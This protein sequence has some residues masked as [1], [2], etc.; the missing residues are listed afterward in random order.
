MSLLLRGR[1][2]AAHGI[3]LA[4]AA[5]PEAEVALM[6]AFAMAWLILIA[7]PNYAR[8]A[9]VAIDDELLDTGCYNGQIAG[10]YDFRV[11][12]E[13]RGPKLTGSYYYG[14]KS[15][16]ALNVRGTVEQGRVLINEYDKGG[17]HTGVFRGTYDAD[18]HGVKGTW[19]KPDNSKAMPFEFWHVECRQ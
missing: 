17:T 4:I 18:S 19:S 5:Q 1:K 9:D 8:A 10:K 7:L 16:A 12:L 13:R 2:Q 11:L 14:K 6:K 15:G 3:V